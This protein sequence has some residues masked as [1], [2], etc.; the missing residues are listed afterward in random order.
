MNPRLKMPLRRSIV[1]V[2]AVVRIVGIEM[3]RKEDGR[4]VEEVRTNAT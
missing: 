2:Q 4:L 3:R 1:G